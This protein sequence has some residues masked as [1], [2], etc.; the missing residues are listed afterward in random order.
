MK[1]ILFL[2]LSVLFSTNLLAQAPSFYSQPLKDIDG[3]VIDLN[4]YTGK[5]VLVIVVPVNPVDSILVQLDSF[6]VKHG[7]RISIIGVL[8]EEFG[9]Q[10]ENKTAI[11]AMYAGKNLVLTE[12]M[13]V[14]KA[15]GE[16]QSALLQWLTD[17]TKN[18]HFN[19]DAWGV[20]HKYFIG[21]EGRLFAVMPAK[22]KLSES[23]IDRIVNSGLP[24]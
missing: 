3:N 14:R 13:Q 2:F 15:A 23:I 5:K 1:S 4:T 17:K 9:Y 22:T 21:E 11:K 8:A 10:I 7:N 18:G 16:D 6:A 12:G 19:M 24:Q 20:G